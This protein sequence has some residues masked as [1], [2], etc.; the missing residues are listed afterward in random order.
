MA[1]L[2]SEQ[3]I[4]R[5]FFVVDALLYHALDKED[6]FSKLGIRRQTLTSGSARYTTKTLQGY[7]NIFATGDHTTRAEYYIN[8]IN[9]EDAVT[10]SVRAS[11][12]TTAFNYILD[13][14]NGQLPDEQIAASEVLNSLN[15]FRAEQRTAAKLNTPEKGDSIDTWLVWWA[16]QKKRG[17]K[18]TLDKICLLYTSPSPR[19]GL[20]SRMPSSA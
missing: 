13:A 5:S 4:D 18:I 7:I 11:I 12:I 8:T 3:T 19:D 20:L 17:K 6:F 2:I 16:D 1:D 10:T 9:A 15:Q 14:I